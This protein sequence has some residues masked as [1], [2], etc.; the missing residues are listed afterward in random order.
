MLAY[1]HKTPFCQNVM[2]KAP[3]LIWKATISIV[4]LY[5][6]GRNFLI[7]QHIVAAYGTNLLYNSLLWNL[8]FGCNNGKRLYAKKSLL[9]L[10]VIV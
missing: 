5:L 9:Y 4:L 3:V 7:L 10:K 2:I 8:Y 6:L 1:S